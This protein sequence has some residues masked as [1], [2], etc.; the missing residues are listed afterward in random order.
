MYQCNGDF[1]IEETHLQKIV[2][3]LY[4][5]MTISLIL[6]LA[7]GTTF[8]THVLLQSSV[9]KSWIGHISFLERV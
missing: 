8:Y 9:Q 6:E 7:R 5:H 3:Q 4:F 1:D 2:E